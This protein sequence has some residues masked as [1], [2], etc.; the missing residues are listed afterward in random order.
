MTYDNTAE[1][2][3]KRESFPMAI[4]QAGTPLFH[5]AGTYPPEYSHQADLEALWRKGQPIACHW[6]RIHHRD[7]RARQMADRHYSR[8]TPGA[9]EFIPAGHKVVLM[10][11]A[12]DGTPA[13]LWASHR[14]APCA[15]LARPRFDGLDVWD[16]SI[17][18]IEQRTIQAS[19]LIREAVAITR[20]V[21]P[22]LPSDGFY[23][24]I[25]P[26]HVAPIK[27]RGV[28]I[29]G[30]SY[31]K[32]GWEVMPLRTKAR[33]L[34]QLVLS[35]SALANVRPITAHWETE[36]ESFLFAA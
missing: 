7:V 17:F 15:N 13:A 3:V 36:Q 26:R 19:D 27:R 21:W 28:D 32:A 8:R 22:E 9:A 30:Y 24:T 33:N 12:A 5:V 31:I 10:H 11:F 18:R 20:G 34:V 1:P 4:M 2:V 25:D 29:W 14:A 16:C 6:T 23:T 35:G